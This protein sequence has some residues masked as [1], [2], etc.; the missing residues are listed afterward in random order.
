VLLPNRRGA[1]GGMDCGSLVQQC[2]VIPGGTAQLR[3]A[4]ILAQEQSLFLTRL[5]VIIHSGPSTLSMW[6][7]WWTATCLRDCTWGG[8]GSEL[9]GRGP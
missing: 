1:Q 6:K 9:S 3:A 5:L 7:D 2:P 8:W 4:R